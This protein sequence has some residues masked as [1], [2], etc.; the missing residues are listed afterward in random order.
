MFKNIFS[1]LMFTYLMI[2]TAVILTASIALSIGYSD[3]IFT[4]K[5]QEQLKSAKKVGRL[6]ES[7]LSGLLNKQELDSS[8]N[9]IGYV[10]DSSIYVINAN[11]DAIKD[12]KSINIGEGL[13]EA[14]LLNDLEQ[15][16]EGKTVF[17]KTQYSSKFNMDVVFTGYPLKNRN[18]ISGAILIFSPVNVMEADIK[19]INLIIWI[20]ALILAIISAGIIYFISRR[21]SRPIVQMT[22]AAMK[23]AGGEKVEEI[24]AK[25]SDE[26]EKLADAFNTM[27]KQLEI[28]E[29]VRRE[30]IANVSHDL[31]TP[32]TSINGFVQG[33]IDGLIKPENYPK[34]L[35]IMKEEINRLI[36]LTGDILEIAKIQGGAIKL[37]I[38]D[39]K[40]VD[41]INEIIRSLEITAHQKQV[42]IVSECPVE[43][44]V[45]ADSD[46]LKQILSNLITNAVKYSGEGSQVRISV[47]QEDDFI[48]FA[49]RDNGQ[50]IPEEDLAHVFD[51]FY[52][53]DRTR[54]NDGGTGLGLNIAKSLVEL[55]GGKIWVESKR[56]E[57]T[58]FYLTIPTPQLSSPLQ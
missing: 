16:L 33:M 49:V 47:K 1:R 42:Q 39:V 35:A 37:N 22:D 28:T 32:L 26:I 52:R 34:Y 10:T 15:I 58:S 45:K 38:V 30:F 8:I 55:H 57:G 41:V 50:G 23:L 36:K 29:N 53:G 2:I 11:V 12:K 54:Q 48:K 5:E 14:F 13:D 25:T 17:R 20:C 40:T 43:F 9:S 4:D 31:R 18:Q 24:K 7:Y 44:Y 19:K 27:N 56:G 46:R 21:I 6:A 3:Y 51:K